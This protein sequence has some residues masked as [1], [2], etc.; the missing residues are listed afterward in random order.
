MTELWQK[1][2]YVIST[3]KARL[4]L[5][6]IHAFLSTSYWAQDRAR[7][8]TEKAIEHSLCF[9]IYKDDQQVGFARVISDYAVFAYLADVFVLPPHRGKA[10]GKHLIETMLDYPPLQTCGWALFTK[11]AHNLYRQFGFEQPAEPERLMRRQP[12]S[13]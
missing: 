4:D 2:G 3:D 10:L 6:T 13:G 8:T 5:N 12:A 11:D 1:D 9:G 7:E